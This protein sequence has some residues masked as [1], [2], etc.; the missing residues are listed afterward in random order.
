MKNLAIVGR[1]T[2]TLF[3][4]L[5]TAN[6]W[7]Q[8]DLSGTGTSA[9]PYQITSVADWNAFAT[10]VNGGYDYSGKYIQLEADVPSEVEILEGTP[11]LTTMVGVWD[12]AEENRKPFKGTFKGNGKTIIVSY[13]SDGNYTAPF[14]CTNGATITNDFT[15]VGNINATNG[16]AAGLVG[17][18]YGSKTK[19]NGNVTVRV[20]ITGGGTYC[21]GVAVDA[22]YLEM[23]S[24]LYNGQIIAGD[25]SG[26]FCAKGDAN[27]KF[28]KCIFDAATGS[29]ITGEHTGNY[30]N[31]SY[32]DT[33]SNNY[34]YTNKAPTASITQGVCIYTSTS[35][36]NIPN[37]GQFRILT[38]LAGNDYY[39]IVRTC[40]ISGI[41]QRY[42]QNNVHSD[43]ITYDVMFTLDGDT[44]VIDTKCYT[45]EVLNGGGVAVNLSTIAP[46]TYTLKITG[47]EGYCSGTLTSDS[48]DVQE[49]IFDNGI[50]TADNPYQITSITDWSIFAK[51][52]ND[53]HSFLGEYLKLTNNITVTVKNLGTD[54]IVGAMT[55]GGAESKWFSGTFDGDWHTLTFN[56]GTSAKAITPAHNYSP[57][58]PFRVIDGATIKNLTVDGTIYSTKKYNAGFVG[59]AYNAKTSKVNNIINCTSNIIFD[60][61][62]IYDSGGNGDKKWDC[63]AGGFVAENKQGNIYFNNCIFIGQLNQGDQSN[64]NRGAGF[65]SYN[66]GANM[67]FT[68]CTMAGTIG[69]KKAGTFYR[70]SK[71][72]HEYSNCYYITRPA[73]QD[74]E[75]FDATNCKQAYTNPSHEDLTN[76]IYKHY[77]I[78][79]TD[80]YIPNA[81]ISGLETTTYSAG[82]TIT[83]PAPTVTYYGKALTRG[84]DYVIKKKFG[85]GDYATVVGDITLSDAGDYYIKIET[86]GSNYGGSQTTTMNVVAFSSW[87][88]VQEYL[89][90]ASK[91][92]RVITLSGSIRPALGTDHYLEVNGNVVL[93][94]N[95]DTIDRHLTDST[96]VY[97]QVIRV[98]AGAN[99]TIN[100]PGVITGGFAWAGPT[101]NVPKEESTYYDK[102]DG[103]GIHNMGHLTLNNVN[104]KNNKI[105]KDVYQGTKPT[106]RGGGIYSGQ[107]SSLIINGG[108]V[109]SNIGRGGGGGIYCDRANPFVMTDVDVHSN[110]ADSK[111]GGL[112]IKTTGTAVAYLTR[113]DISWANQVTA[114]ASQGGGVYLESGELVMDN[115]SIQANNATMQGAGFFSKRGKTTAINCDISFNGTMYVNPLN[116]GG[117]ICLYDNKG[118]DHSIYIMDGGRI[119]WN[120]CN[121][122]G[123]GVYVYEGAVFQ[124]KGNVQI[125]DNLQGELWVGGGAANNAYLAGES[126]IEV[127]GPLDEE[128]IINIT[129]VPGHEGV[130]V[131]F[132]DDATSGDPLEDLSHFVLDTDEEGDD[133]Y[134][135]MIDDGGN[136]VV[137]GITEWDDT[138]TWDGT[139][140]T[141]LSGNLPTSSN[142][143]TINRAVKI[144]SDC[145]AEAK[146]ITLGTFGSV[147]LEDGGQLKNNNAVTIK[148][149]KGVVKADAG[150]K[151][152]WYVISSPVANPIIA[153]KTNLVTDDGWGSN[154]YDLYRF[155]ETAVKPWE[156]YRQAGHTNFDI[157]ETG[158]GYLYRNE[159]AHAIEIDGNVN[160]SDVTYNLSCSGSGDF[161][162]FNLIGNPYAENITILNTTLVDNSGI[163]IKD[164]EGNPINLTGY[165]KLSKDD[166]SWGTEITS[167]SATIAPLEGILVQVD[168]ARK[169]KF[170]RTARA[171]A[172]SNGDNIRFTVANEKYEDRTFALFEKGMG[173]EKI[174]HMNEDVPM[175]Y[176]SSNG[177]DYAI[178]TFG[179]EVKQFNLN[180]EAKTTGMYTLGM[181]TQGEFSYLHLIDKVAEKDIDLL[182]EGEYEFIGSSFDKAD[183]FVVRL[184]YLPDYSD[185]G[186]DNFVYQ[187]GSEVLVSGQGEL[188]VF[189]VMGRLVMQKKVNGVESVD[190]LV[191]GV[192]V[193]RIVGESV[194]TK[195]IVVR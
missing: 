128:A 71:A 29:S 125:L 41:D 143:V 42:Y 118:D 44:A 160:V 5:M 158:R 30:I 78:N 179:D 38:N 170:S 150:N 8:A 139:I 100:G 103:G 37:D 49:T 95:G 134:G 73:D 133:D 63:S 43:G 12:A 74:Q 59:F 108:S 66:N 121:H 172:K 70:A 47:K 81:E 106:A 154:T 68:N 45:A 13:T 67:Y 54:T 88:V 26:G 194:K 10:A 180:F 4:A 32:D 23:S 97:G 24:C 61:S 169:V 25:Y 50:G 77:K 28:N 186:D 15:V 48:F 85:E 136:V 65:V 64:A 138:D 87:A 126:V 31:G 35:F 173:L 119:Y 189:D 91:G 120:Q 27:T 33:N 17:V 185:D 153:N 84:T 86:T 151:A 142:N 105:Y 52:V 22:T 135:S 165:Y 187:N 183:R 89:A 144:P 20:N 156:N 34:Y 101:E 130:Y 94:L 82:E 195:K 117:G 57:S 124:V 174:E 147:I 1:F 164:G 80:Y 6:L 181:K 72:K 114:D 62:N 98:S 76:K 145:T 140:A 2:L 122:D 191:T 155:N 96:I 177:A 93:N 141:N 178:A 112:R 188:Q 148:A 107:G 11:A 36:S 102:R 9:D 92:D 110:K 113:C 161:K 176:I 171:A 146:D 116:H 18:N 53:G 21:G 109:S 14:R 16:Y 127:I 137:Y 157:L 184:A 162:G 152:G 90:D 168:E 104:V 56:V 83:I 129:P 39:Y 149:K 55:S 190:G 131:T 7:G 123:G 99:L 182:K 115:C 40:W 175:V 69:L 60:G 193:M 19:I 159:D 79:S 51:A 75:Q 167:T 3:A 132:D 163:Q 192:Y 166:G 46:G 58:A 111:G